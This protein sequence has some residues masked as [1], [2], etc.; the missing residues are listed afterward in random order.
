VSLEESS[1]AVLKAMS[2]YAVW[3]VGGATLVV[4][5]KSLFSESSKSP[6]AANEPGRALT[7]KGWE[8]DNR[9][10][11]DAGALRLSHS[12]RH[13]NGELRLGR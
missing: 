9:R 10:L 2:D 1:K 12:P 11:S 4:I 7:P 8:I 6:T 13:G 3:E 5:G